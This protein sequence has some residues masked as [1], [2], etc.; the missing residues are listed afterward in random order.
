MGSTTT[1]DLLSQLLTQDILERSAS[2]PIYLSSVEVNGGETFTTD[3][4]KKLL[5]PLVEHSDYTLSQLIDTIGVSHDKLLKTNVFKNIDISLHSDYSALL[6]QNIK[7]YNKDKP[8]ATKVIFDL[9]SINLNIGEGFFNVNNEEYLNMKLNYLNNNFNENAEL[10][11]IGVDYNPYKPTDHLITNAKLLANL[12]NPSIKFLVDVFHSQQNNQT[13]QQCSEGATGGIIGLQYNKGKSLSLLS[14]LSIARR[15]IH[16]IDDAAPDELKFFAGDYLKSSIVNQLAY[17]KVGYLNHITKNFGVRGFDAAVSNEISSNQEQDNVK[18]QTVFIKTSVALN[19]YQ[20]VFNNFFTT[21]LSGQAGAI[22]TPT[23]NAPVHISDRFYLGGV[24]SFKGFTRNSLN[25]NGGL[26]FYNLSATVYSKLPSFIYQ[27]RH[28]NPTLLEDGSSNE[29]N[30]LRLYSTVAVG[31]VDNDIL[32]NPNTGATTAGFGLRYFNH[33]ANFD[34][35]YYFASRF[36]V[37]SQAGV[38]DGLQFA[39]SIGGSNRTI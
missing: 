22:Y 11:N 1:K 13:W 14:G 24:H 25:P 21:H 20:S 26:Q 3:F 30:P 27:P 17:S 35:G 12:N 6:P 4:F 9:L 33:W 19:Y 23:V 39:V 18:N 16:N 31:N 5:S 15:S 38:S 34:I 36:G 28:A 32:G 7:N 8:V 10:V 29:A 37:Q 2:Q